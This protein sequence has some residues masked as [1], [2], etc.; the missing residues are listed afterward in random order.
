M[1][2]TAALMVIGGLLGFAA[3]IWLLIA[4]FRVSIGWGL[5]IFF[6]G[7]TWIPLIIFAVKYW[8]E[9]KR[10]ILLYGASV[11]VLIVASLI[12]IFAFGLELDSIIEE[13]GGIIARPGAK[14]D[15][16]NGVLP[17]PRPTAQPTHQSWEAIV[18]EI[19]RDKGD[20]WETFVPSPTPVTG[21]PGE[22]ALGWDEASG[23]IGRRVVIEL[24]N[25]TVV[26]A[27]LEAVEPDRLKI[28]HVIGGGEASYWIDRDQIDLIRRP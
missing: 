23:Y 9:A 19:D 12:A 21:R 15:S 28:R 16:E 3:W 26:T 14:I 17:P 13:G 25:S 22:G 11:V 7:W 6:L 8:K 5:A 24:T 18:R 27:A 1:A 2:L 4:A 20:S 10:P